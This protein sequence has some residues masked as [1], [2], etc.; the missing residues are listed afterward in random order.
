[1]LGHQGWP[2]GLC[3]ILVQEDLPAHICMPYGVHVAAALVA[4]YFL[5][6]TTRGA[7]SSDPSPKWA[8]LSSG[9]A[10]CTND[11]FFVPM[12]GTTAHESTALTPQSSVS[13]LQ[14]HTRRPV[15]INQ[16]VQGTYL[17]LPR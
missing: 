16:A 4:C 1:M 8:A 10:G 6:T 14:P 3:Q 2:K 11:L 17:A 7:A 5:H 13:R 9:D 12:P 15:M